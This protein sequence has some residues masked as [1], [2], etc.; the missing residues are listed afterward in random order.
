MKNAAP[1]D[2]MQRNAGAETFFRNTG[3]TIQ[4][5]GNMAAY[6]PAQAG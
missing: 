2:P 5:G 4:H 1:L 3:A 6:I